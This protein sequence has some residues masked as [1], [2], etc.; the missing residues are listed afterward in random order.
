MCF[1]MLLLLKHATFQCQVGDF[2]W[3]QLAELRWPSGERVMRV[4]DAVA[5]CAPS[6]DLIILD[7]KTH[8][9]SDGSAT[10]E[11]EISEGLVQLVHATGCGNCLIWAKSDAVV[12]VRLFFVISGLFVFFL[13][14]GVVFS[15]LC[16]SCAY[17]RQWRPPRRGLTLRRTLLLPP[18]PTTTSALQQQ[19]QSQL[20]SL[21]PL[22][23][24][25]FV[26]PI[27]AFSFTSSSTWQPTA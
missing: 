7:V 2:T 15:L 6:V 13:T 12:Q 3:A 11:R 26:G 16:F 22:Y 1:D 5:L 20:L 4:A 19:W 10:D 25:L 14:T 27:L 17:V 24:K 18:P 21:A 9:G 8:V 23:L